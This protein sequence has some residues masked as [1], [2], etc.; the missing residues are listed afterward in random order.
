[1]IAW[2]LR[3]SYRRIDWFGAFLVTAGLTFI[4]FVLSDGSIAPDGWKPETG[5]AFL[6]VSPSSSLPH[7][8]NGWSTRSP[9]EHFLERAHARGGA[10]NQKC[11]VD[12]Y[13]AHAGLDLGA[14]DHAHDRL[15]SSGV[16]FGPIRATPTAMS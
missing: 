6:P 1:M 11:M 16:A 10:V 15:F 8:A 5:C 9:G 14:R 7:A 3:H 12:T 13:P 4:I 2:I